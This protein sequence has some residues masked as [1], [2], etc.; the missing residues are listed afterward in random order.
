MPCRDYYMQEGI[1]IVGEFATA[2]AKEIVRRRDEAL[3]NP[4]ALLD[5]DELNVSAEEDDFDDEEEEVNPDLDEV[6]EEDEYGYDVVRIVRPREPSVASGRESGAW[7]AA[8]IV[9]FL[10]GWGFVYGVVYYGLK[11][12]AALVNAVS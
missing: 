5:E 8:G 12:V 7:V 10:G 6:Y 11:L 1:G 2:E 4:D 3:A 9:L